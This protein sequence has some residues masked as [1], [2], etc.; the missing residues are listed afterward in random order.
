MACIMRVY[1]VQDSDGSY[2]FLSEE[3][4]SVLMDGTGRAEEL[5]GQLDGFGVPY[6]SQVACAMMQSPRKGGTV[7]ER[8]TGLYELDLDGD[9]PVDLTDI[10]D[11][12]K[13]TG[14][15]RRG[16]YDG[17]APVDVVDARGMARISPDGLASLPPFKVG[18]GPC[19]ML[20]CEDAGDGLQHVELLS[21]HGMAIELGTCDAYMVP[22]LSRL[23]EV[24]QVP[25]ALERF[26]GMRGTVCD[27]SLLDEVGFRE[28]SVEAVS[29]AIRAKLGLPPQQGPD[30]ESPT[31]EQAEE[32]SGF[33]RSGDTDPGVAEICADVRDMSYV[34]SRGDA[35]MLLEAARAHARLAGAGLSENYPGACEASGSRIP[36]AS[37]TVVD[38]AWMDARGI[39]ATRGDAVSGE[40]PRGYVDLVYGGHELELFVERY[41]A[42]PMSLAV[43]AA[44]SAD[45]T[46][47]KTLTA[48]LGERLGWCEAYVDEPGLPGIAGTLADAGL[49]RDTG[50]R[51]MS[52]HAKGMF[53]LMRFDEG[54]MREV[55]ALG[56]SGYEGAYR[57]A[58]EAA[59]DAQA[60]A[61]VSGR[62]FE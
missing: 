59:T 37:A 56:F 39:A 24:A 55:D 9:L 62:T 48:N 25:I 49:A 28:R 50:F 54:R 19:W 34:V 12:S 7:V 11:I 8:V 57:T 15:P 2:R 35:D 22:D 27:A 42:N 18:N 36:H 33:S 43:R 45:G 10:I 41:P 4:R 61:A 40:G 16:T 21:E 17:H 20:S 53:P 58:M 5:L 13:G 26:G 38:G 52:P 1:G 3:S 46:P 6:R 31:C 60:K 30:K 32:L 51:G 23:H 29:M 14:Y 44:D 47:Y